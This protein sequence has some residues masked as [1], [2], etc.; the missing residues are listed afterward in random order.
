MADSG[1][2]ETLN[3]HL[4]DQVELGFTL[5][6]AAA[7][8][9]AD[10]PF[11]ARVRR[12]NMTD[13]LIL[14]LPSHLQDVVYAGYREV[15]EAQKKIQNENH[16]P[17]TLAEMLQNNT[18]SLPAANALCVAAF[19]HPPVVATEEEEKRSNDADTIWI[20][21][22]PSEDRINFLIACYDAS[23]DQASRL[24]MFRPES[25]IDVPYRTV[26]PVAAEPVRSAEPAPTG[27]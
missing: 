4:S 2:R 12:L 11:K 27:V 10:K 26:E 18:R 14:E 1:F 3:K 23:S 24:T 15:R 25:S 6:L 8:I 7:S 9:G 20:E 19:I 5:I 21:R 22:L 17:D 16:D 13:K